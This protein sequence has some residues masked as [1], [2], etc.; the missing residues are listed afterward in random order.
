MGRAMPELIIV[1]LL[2]KSLSCFSWRQQQQ[3]EEA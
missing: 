3:L 1:V 2:I